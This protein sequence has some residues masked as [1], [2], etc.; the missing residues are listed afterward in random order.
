[1]EYSMTEDEHKAL[2]ASADVIRQAA[3]TVGIL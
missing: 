1:M 3:M 2:L